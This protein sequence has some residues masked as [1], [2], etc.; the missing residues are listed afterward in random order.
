[1]QNMPSLLRLKCRNWLVYPTAAKSRNRERLRIATTPYHLTGQKLL[2]IK[3]IF[4]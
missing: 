2:E 4:L 3:T 1:M